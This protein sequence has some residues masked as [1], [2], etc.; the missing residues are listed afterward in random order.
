[1]ESRRVLVVGGGW[2]G[3]YALKYLKE[4]GFDVK[5][6]EKT[7]TIG[8]I[9]AYREN[10]PGGVAKST[11]STTSKIY[12]HASDYPMPKGGPH[13]PHHSYVLQYLRDYSEHFGLT[14]FIHLNHCVEKA[15]KK[16]DTWKA[17][18]KNVE[19]GEVSVERFNF[20]GTMFYRILFI[21]TTDTVIVSCVGLVGQNNIPI[22]NPNFCG[23]T[24]IDH[25]NNIINQHNC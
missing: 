3:L 19:T 2:C 16:G 13:F 9:W 22:S 5:L 8:G 24:G 1:M 20:L 10:Q 23:Y 12:M 25:R 21:K 6:V 18:I 11:Y 15:R 7:D 14:P 4:E 17:I